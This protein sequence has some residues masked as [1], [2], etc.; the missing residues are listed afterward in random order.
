MTSAPLEDVRREMA[1]ALAKRGH[2]VSDNDPGFQSVVH[3]VAR[4]KAV[5][6]LQTLAPGA[7]VQG[8]SR[9]TWPAGSSFTDGARDAAWRR[10]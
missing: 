7:F 8:V 9:R 4:K 6:R 3:R 2:R 10:A 5:A 1:D